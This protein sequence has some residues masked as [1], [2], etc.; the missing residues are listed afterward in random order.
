MSKKFLFGFLSIITLF[1]GQ[2]TAEAKLTCAPH[3]LHETRSSSMTSSGLDEEECINMCKEGERYY[4]DGRCLKIDPEQE[5]LLLCQEECMSSDK[6]IDETTSVRRA[7]R[8]TNYCQQGAGPVQEVKSELAGV[9]SKDFIERTISRSPSSECPDYKQRFSLTK[10]GL[11]DTDYVEST[12]KNPE[13]DVMAGDTVTI[14]D[15]YVGTMSFDSGGYATLQAGASQ[16]LSCPRGEMRMSERIRGII[17]FFFPRGEAKKDYKFQAGTG[18]II[19]AIKGTQFVIDARGSEHS[20][21]VFEGVVDASSVKDPNQPV[22]AVSSGQV[23][24]G[25]D[26]GLSTPQTVTVG[27]FTAKYPDLVQTSAKP[28]ES[29][30]VIRLDSLVEEPSS[31]SL[32]TIVLV[33]V[34]V[35]SIFWIMFKKFIGKQ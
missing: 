9:Y 13:I 4:G 35:L 22:V 17:S 25:N 33:S 1:F 11:S 31:I 20:I 3:Q 6:F 24:T 23:I 21:Y 27:E 7:S 15:G 14:P 19:A 34:G 8:C 18:T 26:Q 12:K 2:F 32:K 30:G 29:I 5:R 16:T 28:D 10:K